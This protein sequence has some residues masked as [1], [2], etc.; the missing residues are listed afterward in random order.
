MPSTQQVN[1]E[2]LGVSVFV[3]FQF[4]LKN[5]LKFLKE[6]NLNKKDVGKAWGHCMTNRKLKLVW[7]NFMTKLN[8]KI[9][10]FS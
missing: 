10:F 5:Q 1:Q 3:L 4:F 8:N 9:R 6:K 2:L 7:G